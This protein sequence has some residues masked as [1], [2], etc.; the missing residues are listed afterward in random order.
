MR[1]WFGKARGVLNDVAAPFVN[2]P[3]GRSLGIAAIDSDDG[4]SIE[5]VIKGF[6]RTSEPTLNQKIP[7]GNLSPAAVLSIEQ[8]G[9]MNGLTGRKIQQIYED[10]APEDIRYDA[11]SL[12]EYAC[13]RYLS[14]GSSIIRGS[15]KDIAFQR[16][17]FITMLAWQQP[18]TKDGDLHTSL[19][20]SSFQILV[21]EKAFIRIAS[22]IPDVA[23]R[24]ISHHLFKALVGDERGLSL[25]LWTTYISEL[26]KVHQWKSSDNQASLELSSEEI[27]CVESSRKQP[28]MKLEK[29]IARPGKL[30]LT[31][32][33][34]YFEGIGL[35]SSKHPMKFDL[36]QDDTRVEKNKVGPFGSRLFDSA[37]T[38]SSDIKSETWVLEF[39]DFGGE[40]R[41]DV[42][43]AFISEIIC[44]YK[45]IHE[46][47]PLDDD[48]S[49]YDVYD[50]HKGMRRAIRSATKSIA[51]LKSLHS[52]GKLFEDPVKLMQFTYL[53]SA[54]HGDVVLQT[55]AVNIWGGPLITKFKQ[56][57][58]S[59]KMKSSDKS[60][61]DIGHVH[62]IDG[63][64]YLRKWMRSKSWTSNSS[65]QFWKDISAK[66]GIILGKNL[67]VGGFDAIEKA[68]LTCKE[69]TQKV[70]K[71]QETIDAAMIE[72]IPSNIDLLKELALP[73]MMIKT[74]FE[75][76]RRWEEPRYTVFFLAFAYTIIFRNLLPYVFP[77][78]LMILATTILLMKGLKEQGRLGRYF[79]KV[80]IR[81]QPPSNTIQKIIALKKALANLETTLQTINISL[82]KIRTIMLS[83]QPEMS[84]DVALVLLSASIVFFMV[85]FRYICAFFLFDQFTR[86][87]DFRKEMVKK[88]TIFLEEKWASVQASPVVVLP[89]V[90]ND[91]DGELVPLTEETN[92]YELNM[93][94][95][96]QNVKS[97]LKP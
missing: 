42:W 39:I 23:D 72:G 47:G 71:T 16:L 12:V 93:V 3:Q 70:E 18:Y 22:A 88:F 62:D 63:S 28:V 25:K 65:T 36:T 92:K 69:K 40:T 95:K 96:I 56:E 4:T 41:R 76:L 54:P 1:S 73:F 43:H 61:S 64:V 66:K 91:S 7:T 78:L 38:I 26:L 67:V 77:M 79:G 6:L 52:I 2:S 46:Y 29:N 50:A 44:L 89:Y 33:A 15:L 14:R 80:T 60:S 31:S 82:L 84:R 59:G 34:L 49:T 17:I 94:D 58:K 5:D 75:K 27:L 20:K 87:L 11:R 37:I 57:N 13:F 48:L 83:G 90:A 19:E 35:K 74:H 8:F 81:D 55:L 53:Q 85:P 9:R 97:S 86:K 30:I 68:S 21:G 24:S 32:K 10:V 45:F 51:R